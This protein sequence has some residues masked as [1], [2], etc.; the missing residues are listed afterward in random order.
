MNLDTEFVH[1]LIT[2]VGTQIIIVGG[3]LFA[4]YFKLKGEFS[5]SVKEVKN[6]TEVSVQKLN[7]MLSY[8][9]D[10]FDR[11]A[12]IKVAHRRSVDGEI[13]FRM[14]E[15]NQVY[16]DLFGITKEE[17]IG[18][19]DL[20]AGWSKEAADEFRKNDLTVWATGEPETF[21]EGIAGKKTSVRKIRLQT[22][23]GNLKGIMGYTVDII[24]DI[25]LK[26]KDFY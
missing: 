11:P 16:C 25:S 12:W 24:D 14:L 10:S 17:Y 15:V 4:T 8:V 21:E 26:D 18:K 9:V 22:S 20:E 2:D 7:G 23:D 1:T 13:E 5:N 6:H 19:T 3:A